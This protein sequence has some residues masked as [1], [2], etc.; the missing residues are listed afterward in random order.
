MEYIEEVQ[1]VD[2][3]ALKKLSKLATKQVKL[4]IEI[5]NLTEQLK[6]LNKQHASLSEKDIPEL[7]F[8]VGVESLKL[9]SGET[10]EIKHGI[11]ATIPEKNKPGAYAWLTEKGFGALIK[12]QFIL[13]YG[14]GEN[15]K[16]ENARHILEEK[17]LRY[18]EKED[19]HY[20]TLQKQVREFIEDGID[21]PTELINIFEW[22][23][24]II[25]K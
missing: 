22:Q 16:A 17:S 25:K 3:E 1:P 11:K 13:E 19:I 9:T 23:K 21:F 24:T 8:E 18:K 4:E 2:Q 12:H 20:Q 10:I 6:E 15:E 14:K 7:M 5:R